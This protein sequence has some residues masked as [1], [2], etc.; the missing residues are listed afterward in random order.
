[1]GVARG[2]ESKAL[3]IL[4]DIL[5]V[6]L[7]VAAL[8]YVAR[9]DAEVRMAQGFGAPL[10]VETAAR[11]PE[12]YD[13][14]AAPAAGS[15]GPAAPAEDPVLA[16]QRAQYDAVVVKTALELQQYRRSQSMAVTNGAGRQGLVALT[17]VNPRVNVWHVLAFDWGRDRPRAYYHIENPF[18]RTQTLQLSELDGGALVLGAG[19]KST[20]CE[21]W[22]GEKPALEVARAS[23][24]PYAPLCG[25]RIFLRNRVQGHYTDLEQMTEFLR[26]NVWNGDD[27]VGFVRETVY[28]DAY[29][30]SGKNENAKG[31][32]GETG[33]PLPRARLKPS[34]EALAVVPDSLGLTV[35]GAAGRSLRL[36]QWYPVRNVAG[37]FAS[38]MRPGAA[39][40]EIV[41][42]DK[43]YLNPLDEVEASALAYLVAF[44]L[45]LYEMRFAVGTDHPRLNWSA[46]VPAATVVGK[47]PGP[48]G[49]SSTEPLVTTG[50][51]GPT[52]PGRIVATFSGGF[53]REHGAFKWGELSQKNFGSHY[54]FVEAGAVLSKLQPGLATLYTLDDGSFGMKTWREA[55]NAFLS[56]IAYARQ[57]GVALVEP[58]ADGKPVSGALVN[59]WGPGNWSGS[60]DAK[61]RTLRG[62][63]CLI[64]TGSRQFLV[65]GY[66]STATPSAMAIAFRAYGCSYALNLDMNALEHTY[67]A[68]YA[69]QGDTMQ[70]Q[71]LVRGMANVDRNVKGKLIPRFMGYP[72]NR[73]LFY[74]VKRSGTP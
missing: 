66:F 16:A 14:L 4:G 8:G 22:T 68:L 49:V 70:V 3:R 60:A 1:M 40:E 25:G 17:S 29:K 11:L 64:T 30:E 34:A 48:D 5:V 18:R 65:Y 19:G 59:R 12:T 13:L 6:L 44:D 54:G 69:R 31:S 20:R 61:L 71:H 38:V 58:G 41:A 46:R 67:M 26:D 51:V 45:G 15:E 23:K 57:N 36:G 42:Q 7:L 32:N 27:I 33:A 50:M 47:L 72:D 73:D 28:Q 56:R 74:L 52:S 43:A 62:G 9:L 55:D 35:E 63:A 10:S 21:L 37:T 2:M 53:K 24:L 39:S